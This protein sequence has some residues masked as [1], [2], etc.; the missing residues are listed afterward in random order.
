MVLSFGREIKNI[1]LPAAP[2]P[3]TPIVPL[4]KIFT[5]L[6]VGPDFQSGLAKWSGSYLLL[7][8]S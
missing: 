2:A 1:K 7:H 4:N 3:N 5:V 8:P 6:F